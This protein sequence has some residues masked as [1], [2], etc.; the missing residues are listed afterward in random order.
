LEFEI[1]VGVTMA[2]NVDAFA[3]DGSEILF[4]PVFQAL[5]QL[6]GQLVDHPDYGGC[7]AI[8]AWM[9]LWTVCCSTSRNWAV[10]RTE[11]SWPRN[12]SWICSST[13]QDSL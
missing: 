4:T 10:N 3:D 5:Q 9:Q 1:A 7:R 6:Y 11:L 2:V 8:G 12:A 13:H